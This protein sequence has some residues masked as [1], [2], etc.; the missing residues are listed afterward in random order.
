M[1]NGNVGCKSCPLKIEHSK[2]I[3][4]KDAWIFSF[5][6]FSHSLFA[7]TNDTFLL[8]IYRNWTTQQEWN[9]LLYNVLNVTISNNDSI[10]SISIGIKII[11]FIYFISCSRQNQ[12]I[13]ATIITAE[14]VNQPT[15]HPTDRPNEKKIPF[16]SNQTEPEQTLTKTNDCQQTSRQANAGIYKQTNTHTHKQASSGNSTRRK[17]TFVKPD[18]P[19]FSQRKKPTAERKKLLL[20]GL[21]LEWKRARIIKRIGSFTWLYLQRKL[22]L[23][24]NPRYPQFKL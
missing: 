4:T 16:P 14:A 19:A 6:Y 7:L 12:R 20:F 2:T 1:I 5:H 3:T 10:I 22:A 17:A 13:Q 8:L 21:A 11:I 18:S 15:N 9:K 23:L 24:N